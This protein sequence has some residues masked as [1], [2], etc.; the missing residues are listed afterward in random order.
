MDNPFFEAVVISSD[1]ATY[2]VQ[3]APRINTANVTMQGIVLSHVIT[4]Y[5]GFKQAVL[6]SINSTVLCYKLS[7]FICYIIGIVPAVSFG[8]V[9]CASRTVLKA[10]D[11]RQDEQNTLGYGE[12]VDKQVYA[13]SNRPTDVV[14]GEHVISN[15]LGV[16]MGLIQ[17]IAFLKGSDLAQVQCIL[18]DD[19]VRVISHNYEHMTSMGLFKITHDGKSLNLEAG[20]T[21]LPNEALGTPQVEETTTPTFEYSANYEFDDS[22]NFFEFKDKE[23][24]K[25]IERLKIFLGRLGD[26]L[27]IQLT[28]PDPTATR[29]L[30]GKKISEK[31]DRGL[32]DLHIG[33]DGG[34][35][36]RSIKEV[37]IE[38]VNWIKVPHRILPPEHPKGDVGADVEFT[39]KKLFQWDE[40]FKEG[41]NPFLYFLQLADYGAYLNE[42]LGYEN[43]R[44]HE[45]DFSINDSHSKE[46]PF[47]DIDKN[48]K[49][50]PV[51]YRLAVSGLYLMENGGVVLKDAFGSAIV[52]EGGNIYLQPA[53]DLVAQPLRNFIAK[54]GRIF[55]LSAKKQI[56]ISSTE[57]GLR[58]KTEKAQHYY[59]DKSG[60]IL[61]A[62]PEEEVEHTPTDKAIE[63]I[64]GIIFKSKKGIYEFCETK[65]SR[66][67]E[68]LLTYA[69]DIHTKARFTFLNE[70]E[71]PMTNY[72]KTSLVN[73]S[74]GLQ[75]VFAKS[76]LQLAGNSSTLIGKKDA[77]IPFTYD[78]NSP[79]VDILKGAVSDVTDQIDA[80][81]ELVEKTPQEKAP[82][83]TEDDTIDELKFRYLDSDT[84]ELKDQDVIPQAYA[85][86]FFT[87]TDSSVLTGWAE[88]EVNNTLPYPGKDK[89]ETFFVTSAI[90][91]L[92]E[93]EKQLVC[94]DTDE[95]KDSSTLE[96]K[97]LTEYQVYA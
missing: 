6:P 40:Q 70:S 62:N 18:F 43:F 39:E 10:G 97:S 7:P 81:K 86:Q 96:K 76:S 25:E 58:I 20:Y 46:T 19:L 59:S 41:D 11:T 63:T 95:L 85:Q 1:A 64:G 60:I 74:D 87:L 37:F 45:K 17:E 51:N 57:E 75:S 48:D 9:P 66:I 35:H 89:F 67:K 50:T 82:I 16:L 61:E 80:V 32:F 68:K 13:G 38:K 69:N 94:K 83:Y 8:Q 49:E 47:S 54:I 71:G 14:E 91:N 90:N 33:N 72:S 34:A 44:K 3:V 15:E 4:Q 56:D 21:H 24:I 28:R 53:K 73:V 55:S 93:E 2:S 77:P 30:D 78:T 12:A 84:Y 52:M 22:K 42:K 79:Y 29:Y 36:F 31:F 88:K 23:T 5:L 26:F 65:L 92:K 27:R